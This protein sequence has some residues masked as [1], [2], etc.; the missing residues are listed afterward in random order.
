MPVRKLEAMPAVLESL[1]VDPSVPILVGKT[2]YEMAPLTYGDF[3]RFGETMGQIALRVMADVVTDP[4]KV[5][6]LD[7]PERVMEHL[8]GII[9]ENKVLPTIVKFVIEGAD[10]A[11]IDAMTTN[12]MAD[13]GRK[14]IELNFSRLPVEL[15]ALASLIGSSFGSI[16]SGLG[17]E[18]TQ[19]ESTESEPQAENP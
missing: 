8:F 5:A 2:P 12:Q 6:Q 14:F 11:D 15:P 13:I 4:E 10:P 3:S 17:S 7:T 19:S 18:P 9:V 16:L 1:Q